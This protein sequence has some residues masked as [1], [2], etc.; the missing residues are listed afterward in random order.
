MLPFWRSTEE[1]TAARKAQLSGIIFFLL[2]PCY[3]ET[4]VFGYV[5]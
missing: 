1:A 3:A 4:Y 5:N 2:A